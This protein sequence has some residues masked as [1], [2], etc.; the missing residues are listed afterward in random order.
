MK[1]S[2]TFALVGVSV[3]IGLGVLAIGQ[4]S[5]SEGVERDVAAAT[6]SPKS[7]LQVQPSPRMSN[8]EL[9]D[10]LLRW[11]SDNQNGKISYRQ[12]E[13]ISRITESVRGREE[14]Y[15]NLIQRISG[16]NGGISLRQLMILAN[17][18]LERPQFESPIQYPIPYGSSENQFAAPVNVPSPSDYGQISSSDYG[19]SARARL[20]SELWSGSGAGAG[21]AAEDQQAST[22]PLGRAGAINP[23]TGEYYPAAGPGYVST[24]DGRYYAPAG[25]NGAIDTRTGE[26]VPVAP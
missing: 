5:D 3:G 1:Q 20:R 9:K 19:N 25:P 21:Y 2:S 16:S 14:E 10:A 7:D 26:F 11:V 15:F 18:P 17:L 22:P 13:Y 23:S 6:P 24:R 12:L 8:D 4:G